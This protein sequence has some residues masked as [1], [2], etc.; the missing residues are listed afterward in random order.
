M[1]NK[2]RGELEITLGEEHYNT[3]LNFD[4]IA[5]IESATNMSIIKLAQT[6]GEASI[7]I[8]N[9]STILHIAIKGG[10]KDISEKEVQRIIWNAG[11]VEGM[12]AA[13]EILT[14]ALVGGQDE[15][16]DE[17]EEA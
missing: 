16:K 9:L 17:A 15:G 2:H 13:G 14:N 4:S 7:G 3:R 10:G 12:A 1:A 8:Q 6:I 11:I 5:R